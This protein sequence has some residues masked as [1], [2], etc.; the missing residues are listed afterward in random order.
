[1]K[2]FAKIDLAQAYHQIS[3]DEESRE[4]ITV[5]TPIGLVRWKV[6]PEGIKTA[7]AIFQKAIET[8]I[9]ADITNCVAYQDDIC[10][11]AQNQRR[12]PNKIGTNPRSF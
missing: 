6:L 7:S 2:H 8:T 12:T 9:G 11:G 4:L 10:C 5:N 3:L 1:M